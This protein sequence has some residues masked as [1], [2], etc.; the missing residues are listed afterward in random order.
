MIMKWNLPSVLVLMTALTQGE[1]RQGAG[2][3][4]YPLLAP[5]NRLL[6][7]GYK[8]VLLPMT[9]QLRRLDDDDDDDDDDD[10][11]ITDH[12]DG[13]IRLLKRKRMITGRK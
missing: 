3:P 4:V 12:T 6:Q 5:S 9:R 7:P 10:R 8:G 11:L 13:R 1:T 2:G